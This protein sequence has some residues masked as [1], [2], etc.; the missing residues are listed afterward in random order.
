VEKLGPSRSPGK[1][2]GKEKVPEKGKKR[3]KKGGGGVHLNTKKELFPRREKQ[4]GGKH[5]S[6]GSP[7]G[8]KVPGPGPRRIGKK[9]IRKRKI[10]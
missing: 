5:I 2:A 8:E 4:N 9:D 7:A 6:R 1:I 3:F 10:L